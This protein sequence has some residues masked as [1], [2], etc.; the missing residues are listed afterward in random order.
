MFYKLVHQ[1]H[2][3]SLQPIF[4]ST[5]HTHTQDKYWKGRLKD[6]VGFKR[7]GVG[8]GKEAS[9]DR[10][11]AEGK[12]APLSSPDLWMIPSVSPS[13]NPYIL[14]HTHSTLVINTFHQTAASI[15]LIY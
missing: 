1:L 15:F 13:V 12:E 4:T 6:P 3:T 5:T 10:L 2:K 9:G 11:K 8:E 14:K 7:E